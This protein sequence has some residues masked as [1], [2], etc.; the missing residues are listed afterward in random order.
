MSGFFGVI[1]A[2]ILIDKFKKFKL[3]ALIFISFSLVSYGVIVYVLTLSNIVILFPL[4]CIFGFSIQAL[5]PVYINFGGELTYPSSE[6]ISTTFLLFVL[7][8]FGL[9][10]TEIYKWLSDYGTIWYGVF[11]ICSLLMALILLSVTKEDLKRS[12]QNEI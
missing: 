6:N 4:V 3:I 5:L 8:L 1:C 10:F 11:V 2:G 12:R 9:I 7:P